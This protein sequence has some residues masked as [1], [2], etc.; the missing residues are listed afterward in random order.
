MIALQP[1]LFT[2]RVR[3]PKP[4][5]ELKVHRMIV[6]T[7]KVGLTPGWMVWHTPNGGYALGKA[8]AGQLKAMGVLAGVSDFI[9]VAPPAGRVHALELKRGGVKP[10]IAQVAF[11]ASVR[12]AG[13]LA[14]WVDGY[15]AA[16][17]VLQRWGAVRIRL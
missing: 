8:T 12:A 6:D 5:L 11:L 2:K 1:D 9:L 3:K 13:G 10:S 15:D 4:A 7:L 16:M 17:A 14:E